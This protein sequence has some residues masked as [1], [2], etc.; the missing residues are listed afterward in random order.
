M[1]CRAGVTDLQEQSLPVVWET[2]PE[3]HADPA[4]ERHRKA[5]D[6]A[7]GTQNLNASGEWP[8]ARVRHLNQE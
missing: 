3:D 4:I 7:N 5:P 6:P 2:V 8:M 1:L